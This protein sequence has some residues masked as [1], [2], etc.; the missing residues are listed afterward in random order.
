ME[1]T[2]ILRA[3]LQ[4]EAP[5]FVAPVRCRDGTERWLEVSAEREC[6]AQGRLVGHHGRSRDVTDRI[7]LE[8]ELQRHRARLEELVQER[9]ADLSVAKEAAEAAA[10]AKNLFLSNISHELRTPLTLILGM[11]ELARARVAEP[12]SQQ[13]LDQVLTQA[14]KLTA[15]ITDLID[16]AALGARRMELRQTPLQVDALMHQVRDAH[17]K[18]AADKGLVLVLE[19]APAVTQ[20]VVLGD[21]RRLRQ[22]LAQLTD[23]AIKFTEKGRVVLRVRAPRGSASGTVALDFEV[24]D[25]GIGIEPADHWLLFNAFEQADGSATR[26][27]EGTGLGLALCKLL[28]QA[29]DGHIEVHSQPGHGSRFCFSVRLGLPGADG[30]AH[31]TGPDLRSFAVQ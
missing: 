14:R 25:T 2:R 15:L 4:H 11:S 17:A 27:H 7:R 10:R 24:E 16:Y 3:A 18:A 30:G 8:E 19:I 1:G 9:T 20:L 26:K 23:N 5:M 13:L 22:V 21:A 6:D 29:M 12:R 31:A 28:V